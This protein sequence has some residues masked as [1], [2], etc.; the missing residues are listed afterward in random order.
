LQNPSLISALGTPNA[1]SRVGQRTLQNTGVCNISRKMKTSVELQ[2]GHLFVVEIN[3]F[4][5]SIFY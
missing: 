3:S 4:S 1:S 2:T 5:L